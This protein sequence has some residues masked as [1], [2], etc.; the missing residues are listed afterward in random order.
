[1]SELGPSPEQSEIETQGIALAQEIAVLRSQ[2][3]SDEDYQ[4]I[5]LKARELKGLFGIGSSE[6]KLSGEI[7]EQMVEAREVLGAE[8]F[9]GPDEVKAAFLDQVEIAEVPTIP[10]SKEELER[11]KELNQILI[12][13][14]DKAKDGSDLT[15]EKIHKLMNGQIK[16]ETK[17]LYS[18][19]WYKDEEF[20]KKDKPDVSWALVSKE[21][22]P[23]SLDK[24]Y[25]KQTEVLV[26]YLQ[27]EVFKDKEMPSEYAEAI[28]E[29]EK[30]K[31]S[32][33]R[34][35][36]SDDEAKWKEAARR[37]ESLKIN[38]LTRQTPTESIYDLVA[39][40]QHTGQ[41]L[42]ENTRTWTKRRA[43]DGDLVDV[44]RFDAYGAP[45]IRGRPDDHGARLGV[46]FS[47]SH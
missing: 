16:D 41:R 18:V 19:D 35:V 38:Q 24:N 43:S 6:A 27:N 47:R 10:F 29:F 8:N 20:Y 23:D 34:I 39:Y 25:L 37:L 4:A 7:S 21:V 1:M 17:V 45:V 15:M 9:I 2:A 28:K 42:L 33:A 30:E 3:S 26:N 36:E 44:G 5:L 13:R 46:S 32:I 11:A 40:Y 22:T 14:V 31:A 12:L